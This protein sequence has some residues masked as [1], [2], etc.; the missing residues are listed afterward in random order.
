MV[1]IV[2]GVLLFELLVN[3]MLGCSS[4]I[5]VFRLLVVMVV[6]SWLIILLWVGF[7][8]FDIR[9]GCVVMVLWVCDVS[10]CVV[11]LLVFSILV[12]LVNGMVNLLCSMNVI[13]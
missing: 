3:V 13:C 4:D 7:G 10:W 8:F 11:V 6:I 12:I 1:C 2:V 5:I 9:V